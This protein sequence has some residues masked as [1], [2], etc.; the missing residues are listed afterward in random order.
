MM[1]KNLSLDN[2]PGEEWLPVA[3]GG[4]EN[5]YHCSNM[6]RIKSLPKKVTLFNGGVYWTK[7][8]IIRQRLS[9]DYLFVALFNGSNDER[10]DIQSHRVIGFTWLVNNH[11]RGIKTDNRITEIEWST[12][13]GNVQHSYDTGLNKGNN[14]GK[15][16][17]KANYAIR[18]QCTATGLIMCVKEAAEFMDISHTHMCGMLKGIR[19]N[20][21]TFI[22]I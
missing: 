12:R 3:I 10:L 11:K 1:W 14:I 18:V 9:D 20:W 22:Y 2:L 7:E 17:L 4:Y 5:K 16:G 8:K 21:T 15:F 19:T 6:G 13:A